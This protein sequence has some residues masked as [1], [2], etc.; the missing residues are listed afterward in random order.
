MP[1]TR[2]LV[3]KTARAVQSGAKRNAAY[4]PYATGNLAASIE[5]AQATTPEGTTANVGSRLVYAYS[6]ERG[7]PPR[8]IVAKRARNL[9][10]FWRR[11]GQIEHF[12]AVN[13]P[14]TKPKN[15]LTDALKEIAPLYG[16]KVIIY[17]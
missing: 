15:Y 7:S 6:A 12:R 2:D 13:H 5:R 17:D 11:T 14:G 16:F 4:G 9:R 3:R 8:R 10:F 1:L